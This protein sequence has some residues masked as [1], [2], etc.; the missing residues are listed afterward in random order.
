MKAALVVG[1]GLSAADCIVHLLGRGVAVT[2]AYRGSWEAT[3]VGPLVYPLRQLG[4]Y[5]GGAGQQ[6]TC[7]GMLP[8][9][10]W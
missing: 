9:W 1:A 5:Q 7:Y 10:S 4:G 3:K 8:P 6:V 2:H